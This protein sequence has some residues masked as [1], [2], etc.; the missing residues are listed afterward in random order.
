[1]N[2][3]FFYP[4]FITLLLF[5]SLISAQ[6][7]AMPSTTANSLWV[8]R[9][10]L[11]APAERLLHAM[12]YDSTRNVTVMFGGLS[13][14]SGALNETWELSGNTWT[15]RTSAH[16]P[17][18]R[19]AHAMAYDAAR[20]QVVLFGGSD[21]NTAGQTWVWDGVDW[22][23]KT[24]IP[25]PPARYAPQLVY[26][27]SRHIVIMYGGRSDVL[28]GLDDTWEWDGTTWT[29]INTP[30]T[31]G[32][33]SDFE[34]AFDGNRN[35]VVLFGGPD[36]QTWEYDGTDWV[37]VS[38]AVSPPPQSQVAMVYDGSIRR[39]LLLTYLAAGPT[40]QLWQW[41]GA[42]WA[43]INQSIGPA[44]RENETPMIYDTNRAKSILFGGEV[45]ASEVAKSYKDTWLYDSLSNTWSEI[46]EPKNP[47]ASVASIAYDVARHQIVRFGGATAT[48]GPGFTKETWVLDN[49]D[50]KWT[51]KFPAHTPS[52]VLN[53]ALVYDS[54]R[55][56]V[57]LVGNHD[58]TIGL[59]NDLWEW[60]GVDWTEKYPS[61]LPP[62]RGGFYIA[63]DSDRHVIVLFGGE[64]NGL[65]DDTWEYD[66]TD[67]IQKSPQHHPPA[68]RHGGIVYDSGRHRIVLFGNYATNSNETW[69]YD[70][71]DWT[72]RS[73]PM[74]PP[75]RGLAAMA[76][77]LNRGVTVMYGG[78]GP[79]YLSDTWE[80]N[81]T[82]WVP[83]TLAISPGPRYTSMVYN[84][85]R[86]GM[87]IVA[88][89]F[90]GGLLDDTWEYYGP[91]S[92]NSPPTL[93]TD[94]ASTI[95]D[96]GQP[97]SNTGTYADANTSDNV[98]LSASIG[99]VNKSGTSSGSWN[100]SYATTD[101]PAQSQMVIITANDGQGGVST[102]SFS[103]TVNNVK[104]TVTAPSVSPEPSKENS[105]ITVNATFSDPGINDAPV[106][107]TIN[108][109][110]ASGNLVGTVNGNTCAGP[111]HTYTRYGSYMVTVSVTD[112][113][114][115]TGSNAVTHAVI[116]NF[117]GFFQPV[118]NLPVINVAKAGTAIP[119]RFS[120]GGNQVLAIL[121]P[122]YPASQQITCDTSA[123]LSDIEQTVTAGSSS[124]T[125][126]AASGQYI[127]TWKTDKA[128]AGTCRQLIIRLTDGTEHKANFQFK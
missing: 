42:T 19:Y 69:E 82:T 22:T 25:N 17:S 53:S 62:L 89:G 75:G 118:D 94:N 65:F 79:G 52:A 43:Q 103:L 86:H 49:D 93:T 124:L 96:E 126:D 4:L 81:G 41:D 107:C 44:P 11:D 74:S 7:Q 112:K 6:A 36:D 119:V 24:P 26:D 98:T 91:A 104:P 87:M 56:L 105:S 108:Y 58:N 110:D 116:Y 32:P 71:S 14:G 70:G 120:L 77:D 115:S 102:S 38:P 80:Y 10:P 8:E 100:W 34:M 123:P 99:T 2:R 111:M 61:T 12:A 121:A 101:G 84:P 20:Q 48:S 64:Y 46:A 29:Q 67:W 78:V 15:K 88:G 60:D 90:P 13:R 63:Y 9:I 21:N 106:T 37:N 66:G 23:Q 73:P 59:M 33:R 127:Y 85:D 31:A 68:G 95:V 72:L 39:I 28:G 125:Y 114:N 50:T 83:I 40:N 3:N 109:G 54:S 5:L 92:S 55:A 76:Y 97:A 1:M 51:R 128:W 30:H 57:I 113:D 122:S 117:S 47:P 18:A 45:I 16:S 27:T 35:K